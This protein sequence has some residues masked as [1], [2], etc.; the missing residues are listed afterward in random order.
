MTDLSAFISF[1]VDVNVCQEVDVGGLLGEPPN[2]ATSEDPYLQAVCRAKA[3]LR[4]MEAITQGLYDD[5]TTFFVFAQ[6]IPFEWPKTGT[7]ADTIGRQP[8]FTSLYSSSKV[9][10]SDSLAAVDYLGKLLG[11]SLEQI[12]SEDRFRESM[13]VR[14][15]RMS[16]INGNRRLSQFFGPLPETNNDE[17][18]VVDMDFAFSKPPRTNLVALDELQPAATLTEEAHRQSLEETPLTLDTESVQPPGHKQ[19]FSISGGQIHLQEPPEDDD[20]VEKGQ[21]FLFSFIASDGNSDF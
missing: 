13:A 4:N 19:S 10:R 17:E 12:A 1:L 16:I 18:D 8:L 15:S 5:G 14:I 21:L 20:F 7:A 3:L 9:L 6:N 2:M 11:I